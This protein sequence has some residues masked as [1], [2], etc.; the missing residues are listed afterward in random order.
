MNQNMSSLFPSSSAS[1][2]NSLGN[3]PTTG[4]AGGLGRNGLGS[5]R[6]SSSNANSSNNQ[7]VKQE[8]GSPDF[9]ASEMDFGEHRNMLSPGSSSPL[10]S[11]RN[12]FDSPD[13]FNHPGTGT[14]SHAKPLPMNIQNQHSY[15]DSPGNGS[16]YSP[17]E[18][19]FFPEGDFSLPNS[20]RA[21]DMKFGRH[22]SLP[23][24]NP[25]HSMSMPVP[26]S[27]WFGTT[28]GGHL[29]GSSFENQTGLQF[30]Q[31]E[32]NGMMT[33]LFEEDGDQN[34]IE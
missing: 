1:S 3:T 28:D 6:N 19:D 20:S 34:S 12:D 18:S 7:S 10:N 2:I 4:T 9:M 13:D 14:L 32:M 8:A 30:P 27:D 29:I 15:G 31:G 24:A 22:M 16:L 23:S 33:S 5:K 17:V 26:R 25:F 11:P 21:L